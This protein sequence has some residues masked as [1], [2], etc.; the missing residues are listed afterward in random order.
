MKS[1]WGILYTINEAHKQYSILDKLFN[2]I[3]YL[4]VMRKDFTPLEQI[5]GLVIVIVIVIP[6]TDSSVGVLTVLIKGPW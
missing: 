3:F 5:P 1:V 2:Y 4:N 6:Q